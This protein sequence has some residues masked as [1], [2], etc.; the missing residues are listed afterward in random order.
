[1]ISPEIEKAYKQTREVIPELYA[2][3][4]DAVWEEYLVEGADD[5]ENLT[6]DALAIN[7]INLILQDALDEKEK[8]YDLYVEE[9]EKVSKFLSGQKIYPN[10]PCPCGSGKKYKKCCGK[11]ENRA[12]SPLVKDYLAK[13]E[14]ATP[15]SES[16]CQ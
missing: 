16:P 6:R 9:R 12:D 1:M 5:E 14:Q 11:L 2:K 3:R 10:E 7:Q 4:L 13:A 15:Q 8:E